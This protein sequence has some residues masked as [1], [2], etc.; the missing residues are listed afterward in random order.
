MEHRVSKY[1]LLGKPKF[2]N[3][4]G[5]IPSDTDIANSICGPR[6]YRSYTKADRAVIKQV[7]KLSTVVQRDT[8]MRQLN[9]NLS[10]SENPKP[11]TGVAMES[12]CYSSDFDTHIDST[13]LDLNFPAKA[14][15]IFDVLVT[16]EENKPVPR[17]ST[18]YCKP[19]ID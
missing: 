19:G 10:L 15:T 9:E 3:S 7:F 18:Y 8:W 6:F 17:H 1:T 2:R 11:I 13:Y 5:Q 12:Y 16:N 4:K 14:K